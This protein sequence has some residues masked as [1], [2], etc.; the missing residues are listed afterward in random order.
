[1]PFAHEW[2]LVDVAAAGLTGP[3]CAKAVVEW[4]NDCGVLLPRALVVGRP[5]F[6]VAPG[7]VLLD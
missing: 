1:M 4:K 5:F 7:L 2:N 3:G 6:M